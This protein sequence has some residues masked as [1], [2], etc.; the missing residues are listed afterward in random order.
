MLV[1][2]FHPMLARS[3]LVKDLTFGKNAFDEE[4][5]SRLEKL[6][7]SMDPVPCDGGVSAGACVDCN[8][9]VCNYSIPEICIVRGNLVCI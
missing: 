4:K 2:V 8:G 3:I 1:L 9:S 5:S 7:A 6:N